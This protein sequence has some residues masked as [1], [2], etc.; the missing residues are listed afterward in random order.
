VRGIWIAKDTKR[1]ERHE[2][3]GHVRTCRAGLDPRADGTKPLRGLC[4][5]AVR[6]SLSRWERARA[7]GAWIA[8]DTKRR[9]RRERRGH[10]RA[11][12]AGLNPRADGTKPLR[13]FARS[14]RRL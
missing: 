7:R 9:E 10:V 12:R 11:C 8:K 3:R 14:A 1:R 5:R 13:G 4:Q 2:S 6:R